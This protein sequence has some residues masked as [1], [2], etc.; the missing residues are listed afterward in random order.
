MNRGAVLTFQKALLALALILF[1]LKILG[2]VI[3]NSNALLS[4][5]LETI[6]NIS[7]ALFGLL[8]LRT[9]LKP[10]DEDHPYGHGKIEFVAASF[11]GIVIA[12]SGLMI[13]VKVIYNFIIPEEISELGYGLL[14]AAAAGVLNGVAG[15][16]AFRAGRRYQSATLKA[17]GAHLLSD[18]LSTAGILVGLALA[19]W[20]GQNILDNITA[21]IFG[22]ILLG[23]GVRLIIRS[24][25]DI[26][27]K[28]DPDL[29]GRL[30]HFLE[31]HRQP[32]WVDVHNLRLIKYGADVHVDCHLTVP[33]YYTMEEAHEVSEQFTQ[34]VQRYLGSRTEVFTHLDP[35]PPPSCRHCFLTSC[36]HRRH[37]FKGRI[38]WTPELLQRNAKHASSAT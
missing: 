32:Q 31:E 6:A 23:M 36:T 10:R 19:W 7:A 38:R 18:T 24:A 15:T 2:W 9:A 16:L 37:P 21:L 11:E 26:M 5:A 33:F 35:C 22:L 34:L 4:D 30:I 8:T 12:L 13:I 29:L 20:T 1:A 27:D 25:H 14:I 3:T 28:A 17:A